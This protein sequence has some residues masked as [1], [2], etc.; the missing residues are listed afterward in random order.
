[1]KARNPQKIVLHFILMS[2]IIM[3]S[4]LSPQERFRR[5]PPVPEP[6]P[7]LILPEIFSVPLYNDLTLW[8]VQKNNVPIISLRVIVFAGESASP[9]NLPGLATL[10]ARMLNRGASD[11]TATQIEE[12]IEFIG[13]NFSASTHPDYSLFSFTFLEEYLDQ[14]LSLMSRMLIEPTFIKREID[15]ARTAM[16]YDLVQKSQSPDFLAKRQ[17]LRLLFDNHVYKK[18]TYNEDVLKNLEQNDL[19][20]FLENNYRPNN[21]HI[22]LTSNLSLEAAYRKVG[23]Y[24]TRWQ[25]KEM[26]PSTPPSPEPI[27]QTKVCFIDIKGVKDAT[28]YMG[29]VVM[30][31]T[32]PDIFPLIVM[33][34]VLG[35]TP[36]SRL[37][38]NLRESKGYAYN[39]VSEIEFYKSCSVFFINAKV[40]PEV[41]ES[42][43]QEILNEIEII[44]KN[45][46]PSPEIEEAKSY[47]IGNFPLQIE[48]FDDLTSKVAELKAFNLGDEH[49][50]K[51][52][53]NIMLTTSDKLFELAGKIPIMTPVVVVVGD[54]DLVLNQ[55][56]KFIKEV[57][58]FDKKGI[59]LGTYKF[60]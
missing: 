42:S 23:R 46:V 48:T 38:M 9:D 17:L 3:I 35:G 26:A 49:W 54:G 34:Q 27:K 20:S 4:P 39:A 32:D 60:D 29:N 18:S 6:L 55:F 21:A 12:R 13:G 41:V 59:Y 10:T 43:I 56:G 57:D 40:R 58:T 47:L 16:Y 30:P 53:E 52:Y 1:M 7:P 24:F 11:L 50:N 2:L 14:A 36:N 28:I 8:V 37:F 33:N 45:K 31:A 51:Y 22:I 15:S 19:S 25:K 44:T 5:T